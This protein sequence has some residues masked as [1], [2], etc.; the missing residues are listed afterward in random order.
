MAVK[1][2]FATA[3][4]E[5][6]PYGEYF[7]AN[8][9][10]ERVLFFHGGWGKVA[11]AAST[12]YVIDHFHPARL[13]NLGTCEGVEGRINRFDI[14]AHSIPPELSHIISSLFL[15]STTSIS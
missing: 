6:S 8:I 5:T 11:A 2:L 4:I 15:M 14:D 12:Q 9:E 7:F 13:I 1:P 10:R 3:T